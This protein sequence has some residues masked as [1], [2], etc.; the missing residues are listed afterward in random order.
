MLLAEEGEEEEIDVVTVGD[1]GHKT[2]RPVQCSS[3][4]QSNTQ[5]TRRRR[6]LPSHPNQE[7][8]RQIQLEVAIATK[9]VA[10][11]K[12]GETWGEK[13]NHTRRHRTK[14]ASTNFTNH[15]TKSKMVRHDPALSS[16]TLVQTFRK[17]S[18]KSVS[19]Q[20]SDCEDYG[21][22]RE[23]NDLERK[24]RNDLKS[25]FQVLRK[26]VPEIKSNERA[27]KVL[28][29]SKATEYVH[30]LNSKSSHLEQELQALTRHNAELERRLQVLLRRHY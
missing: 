18:V 4:V 21:K 5:V 2:K 15:N 11:Q 25:S 30:Q 12:A 29:L 13:P 7:T 9:G 20:S 16:R 6:S 14:Y 24:R 1:K 17:T 22:R 3:K 10:K 26:N 19:R 8:R 27:P 23:H 28:I